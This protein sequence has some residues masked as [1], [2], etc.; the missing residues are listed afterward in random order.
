MGVLVADAGMR[1]VVRS[2][3][4][5]LSHL[6]VL[7]GVFLTLC[8]AG[9]ARADVYQRFFTAVNLDDGKTV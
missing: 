8:T 3:L 2:N 1:Q 9:E 5:F 4:R 6:F 7:A